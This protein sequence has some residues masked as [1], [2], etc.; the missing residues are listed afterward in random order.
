MPRSDRTNGALIDRL[1][2]R[3]IARDVQ[4][5]AVTFGGSFGRPP[6]IRDIADSKRGPVGL[7]P[8][9]A[10]FVR[11]HRKGRI[12]A[13]ICAC[14]RKMFLDQ[15][16]PQGN[17]RD[18]H[19]APHGMVRKPDHRSERLAQMGNRRDVRVLWRC[20]VCAGA[21][22]QDDA[23]VARIAS[24]AD[25]FVNFGQGGHSGRHDHG[26]ARCGNFSHER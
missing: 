1:A 10:Q 7:F 24:G 19:A 25:R 22:Q 2:R 13:A 15:H 16:S 5:A 14:E 12:N 23:L 6:A 20:R 17:G 18:R 9:L 11:L 4:G 3:Q 8:Q 21:L 26:L